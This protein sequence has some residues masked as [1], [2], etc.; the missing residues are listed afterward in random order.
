[1]VYASGNP[2]RM[3][4]LVTKAFKATLLLSLFPLAFIAAF[5]PTMAYA[6][7]GQSDP[8][9]RASFWLISV[10]AVFAAFSL[11]ALVLYRV[12]GKALLD[13]V[14]QV[15][16]IAII[17]GVVLCANRLGFYGVL[18]GMALAELV[19]MLF[20]V[21]ALASTFHAFR[22]KWLVPDAIRM[23][24]AAAVIIGIGVLTSHIPISGDIEGRKFAILKL[25]EITLACMLV[26]WPILVGT[27]AVTRNEKD[28]LLAAILPHRAT[29]KF[30]QGS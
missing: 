7:T 26:A 13:N 18:A 4:S 17:V 22:T 8:A 14:R 5:G 19:G 15:L 20:M 6:W 10:R 21:S 2:E 28:A 29:K 16:R 1:M 11:L 9:F 23:I 12:S 24:A 25:G 3:H 30:A 27:G